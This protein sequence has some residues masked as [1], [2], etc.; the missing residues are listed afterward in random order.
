MSEKVLEWVSTVE[1]LL[2]LANQLFPHSTYTGLTKSLQHQWT[3][4]QRVIPNIAHLFS[5]VESAI[6]EHFVPAIYG[7][8]VSESVRTLSSLPVKCA[9]IAITN[10]VKTSQPNYEASTLVCS[11][12]LQAIQGKSEF[13]EMSHNGCLLSRFFRPPYTKMAQTKHANF[14]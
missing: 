1:E 4:F 3:F 12:L 6:T 9:G 13:S 14:S 7:E 2:M 11:H 8:K 5:P 10:P